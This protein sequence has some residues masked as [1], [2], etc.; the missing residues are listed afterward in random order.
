MLIVY[1]FD[2]TGEAYDATQSEDWCLCDNDI[3]NGAILFVPR[4]GVVG[5][6]RDAWPTAISASRGVFHTPRDWSEVT[7][8]LGDERALALASFMLDLGWQWDSA[9]EERD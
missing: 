4:E 1:T 5:F 3:P 6:L 8:H 2:N 9:L 7:R